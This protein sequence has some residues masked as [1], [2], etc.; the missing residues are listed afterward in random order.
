M[1]KHSISLA[2]GAFAASV[3]V[4]GAAFAACP[5]HSTESAQ[6]VAPAKIVQA[7]PPALP[8]TPAPETKTGG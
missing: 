4:A 6:A 1:S 7:N 5:G 2:F 3:L 8:M